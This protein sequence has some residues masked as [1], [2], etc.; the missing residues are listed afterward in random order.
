VTEKE[1]VKSIIKNKK[2]QDKHKETS[3]SCCSSG[4]ISS[5]WRRDLV[6]LMTAGSREK[7]KMDNWW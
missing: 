7:P 2:E 3:S 1:T 4:W 5:S 6:F